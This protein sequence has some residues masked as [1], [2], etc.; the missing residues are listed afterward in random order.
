MIAEAQAKVDAAQDALK[1]AQDALLEAKT[2]QDDTI[3]AAL[4][5][6]KIVQDKT[7]TVQQKQNAVDLAKQAV[8]Q[9]QANY[10]NSL[11]DDPTW[12]PLTE[13][14]AHTRLVSQTQLVQKTVTTATGGV[15]AEVF[16]RLGY[17]ASPPLPSVSEQPIY[18]TTVSSIDFNWGGGQI[19]NSGKYEDII[20]KFTGNIILP[21]NGNYRFY[22][23]ADDGTILELNGTRIIYDWR[24]KGGGGITSQEISL[25]GG[26]MY[27]FTLYYYENGGG[28]SVSFYYYTTDLGYQIVPDT[29]LG[30]QIQETTIWVE[31][32]VWVEET[33][34]TTEIIPNQVAP[35]IKDPA[36]LALI[37]EPTIIYNNAVT[38]YNSAQVDLSLA[39][40]ALKDLQDKQ[41]QNQV[42]I[43][44]AQK[45]VDTTEQ[46][47]IDAKQ[48]LE[49]IPPF[50]DPAPTPEKTTE[51]VKEPEKP[52]SPEIPEPIT[53]TPTELPVNIETV[54]PQELSAEQVTE[55]ISVANEILNSSEQGSPE[56]EQALEALFVAAK[57]D[58]IVIDPALAAIPGMSAAVDAI[59]FMGNVG[60]DMSPKIR[61]ESQKIVVSAVVAVGAA[62]NAATGAALTAAATAPGGTTTSNN[63]NTRRKE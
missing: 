59:N 19:L 27:P 39:Q 56:Y 24:D 55:L 36:L 23:P 4:A 43:D 9:A 7:A 20:V 30:T 5:A 60:A 32:T 58:D 21:A 45:N 15:K 41:L 57:A 14:V 42:T 3:A 51:P 38:D 12:V 52:I 26:V 11:I 40:A 8:N 44:T 61:K 6:D 47:V 28:A 37:D 29:Y 34:F 53:P 10:D 17:N 18:T 22:T 13:Q 25:Q 49:A 63:T 33:F 48:E 35:R 16:N 54:N 46:A 2:L 31:E 50:K 1:Q 62:V